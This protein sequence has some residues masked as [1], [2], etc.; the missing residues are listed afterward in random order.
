M[1]DRLVA[2]LYRL[3]THLSTSIRK[4]TDEDCAAR[5]IHFNG[6]RDAVPETRRV[7]G[8][9]NKNCFNYLD[10]AALS[11]CLQSWRAFPKRMIFGGHDHIPTVYELPDIVERPSIQDVKAYRPQNDQPLVV[12][13]SS[14]SRYWVKAGS[15]GGPYRDGVAAANCVVYDSSAE[16]ITLLRLGR[17]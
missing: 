6:V 2:V 1:G 14:N 10:K 5:W 12:P 4:K 16:T 9:R 3:L 15:I 13:L 17:C 8:M 11:G 7:T